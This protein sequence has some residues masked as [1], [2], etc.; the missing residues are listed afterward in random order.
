MTMN[1]LIADD[2]PIVCQGIQALLA[3]GFQQPTK[4]DCATTAAQALTLAGTEHY[5]VAII[6]IELPDM[7]GN[8]LIDKLRAH[9]RPPRIVVYTMHEEAWVIGS[10]DD[11]KVTAKVLKGDD[12][13]EL[14]TAVESAAMGLRFTSKRFADAEQ[15]AAGPLTEREREVLAMICQGM[16]SSEIAERMFVSVNTIEYHRKQIM[17]RIGA[18]NNAHAVHIAHRD[19]LI[20]IL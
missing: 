3:H 14:I 19:G 12:P 9:P 20:G 5:D 4:A 11:T 2:H 1:I 13:S 10:L 7:T 17:R 18:K 15:R 6:D 8:E 16:K